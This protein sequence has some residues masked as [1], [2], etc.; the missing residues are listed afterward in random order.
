MIK[1]E[2]SLKDSYNSPPQVDSHLCVTI[3]CRR[4][5]MAEGLDGVYQ[6]FYIDLPFQG[7]CTLP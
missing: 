3:C 5:G 2:Y 6:I 4:N 7:L 1:Q